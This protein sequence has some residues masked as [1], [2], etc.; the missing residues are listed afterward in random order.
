MDLNASVIAQWSS[1]EKLKAVITRAA[2]LLPGEV[3]SA[4]LALVTPTALATMVGML[5]LW[6]GSHFL[7]AGLVADVIL[8]SVGVIAL[9]GVAI[10]AGR[11]L[12]LF[13]Q[14]TLSANSETELDKAAEHLAKGIS[15]IGVQ[16][17]L[18]LLLR[19]RPSAFKMPYSRAKSLAPFS[20][21][22]KLPRMAGLFYKPK[23]TFT[24]SR[25]AG[26]GRTNAAGDAVVGRDHYGAAARA[27]EQVRVT[28]YHEKVHQ[29]LTPKLQIFRDIRVYLKQSAYQKSY[30]LRYLEE[31][32]AETYAQCRMYGLGKEYI[33]KGLKFPL[34][35]HY[36]ITVAQLAAELR[37][38][39]LGP[40]AVGAMTYLVAWSMRSEQYETVR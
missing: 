10:E 6:A 34:G 26:D 9:G 4:L 32:L 3:G 40:I 39:V 22:K 15:L 5:V 37:G 31:A 16:V 38:V 25:L 24:K 18:A 29:F 20:Q 8:L 27:A 21:M 19:Q 33:L 14:L 7:G 1:E 2:K 28:T 11:E 13:A 17:A 12:F 30:I 35:S 36:E 23:L